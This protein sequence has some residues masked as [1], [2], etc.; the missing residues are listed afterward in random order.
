MTSLENRF[1]HRPP[2]EPLSDIRFFDFW[3][4]YYTAFSR[5]QDLLVLATRKRQGKAFVPYVRTLPHVH[6][7]H[8]AEAFAKIKKVNY[9]R[10]YSFTSHIAVYDGCPMQYKFYKE[11][12]FVQNRMFHTSVGS[13]VHATL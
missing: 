5:A 4:L 7:F 13:L 1:F 8:G 3:R 12:G 10:M 2:F 9:K 11:Y 6:E